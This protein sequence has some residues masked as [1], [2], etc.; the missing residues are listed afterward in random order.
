VS[1]TLTLVKSRVLESGQLL[2]GCTGRRIH[3][4]AAIRVAKAIA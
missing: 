1:F 4:H 2:S 3:L